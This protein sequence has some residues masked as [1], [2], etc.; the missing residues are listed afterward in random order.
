MQTR[1]AEPR[2]SRSPEP[3]R[4]AG[5]GAFAQE[6]L[7]CAIRELPGPR[8]PSAELSAALCKL[9]DAAHER[10][11]HAEQV[12]ILLK[13]TWRDLP[14]ARWSMRHLDGGPLVRSISLCIDEFYAPRRYT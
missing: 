9:C 5:L 3:V 8:P 11:L 7:R 10:G 13:E 2:N 12:L 4:T 14:E 6:V 1:Q